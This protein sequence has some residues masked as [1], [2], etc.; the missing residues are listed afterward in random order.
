MKHISTRAGFTLIEI[1]VSVGII[2]F[3]SVIIAQA[4]FTTTRVNTKTELINEIKQTGDFA[5]D[6]IVRKLREAQRITSSCTA[7]PGVSDST[8]SFVSSDGEPVTFA[9]AVDGDSVRLIQNPGSIY[10]TGSSVTLSDTA[11]VGVPALQ[12]VCT[13]S[14]FQ[15]VRV[16]VAIKFCLAQKGEGAGSYE[17]AFQVFQTSVALRN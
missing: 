10:L 12:F 4:F 9:S 6:G 16:E 1:V 17:K 8:I 7:A 15:P 14:S 11:C 5:L 3:I 2:A 13:S